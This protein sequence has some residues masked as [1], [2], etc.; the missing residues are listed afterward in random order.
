MI[1]QYGMC[2]ECDQDVEV[3]ID[4]DLPIFCPECRSIDSV[5]LD[6]D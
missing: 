4:S 1:L 5:E 6:E 2:T 3:V